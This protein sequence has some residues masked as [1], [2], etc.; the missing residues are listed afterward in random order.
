MSY[1]KRT[2]LK[3]IS[4]NSIPKVWNGNMYND[5]KI[6]ILQMKEE[7]WNHVHD[8]FLCREYNLDK[9]MICSLILGRKGSIGFPEN[10][11]FTGQIV[12]VSGGD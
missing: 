5:F 11:Y 7:V 12:A 6:S 4:N 1:L 2:S 9:W 8:V 10:T 3:V